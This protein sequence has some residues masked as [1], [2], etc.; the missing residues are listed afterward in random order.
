MCFPTQLGR[1]F[2]H[3]RRPHLE[4]LEDRTLPS[5]LVALTSYGHLLTFDSS[6]PDTILRDVRIDGPDLSLRRALGAIAFKTGATAH[7]ATLYGVSI[8]DFS[9]DHV[10]AIDPVSGSAT[11]LA[12]ESLG[13]F[14]ESGKVGASFDPVSSRLRVV[15]DFDHNVQ[16]GVDSTSAVVVQTDGKTHFATGDV[17]E[18]FGAHINE[19]V[20]TNQVSGATSTTLYA[21]VQTNHPLL[22][23]I[24]GAGGNPAPDNGEVHTIAP[25]A[26]LQAITI[27]GENN[28]A[29]GINDRTV[30][31]IDL[32]SGA[33]EIVGTL[34]A[35]V[36]SRGE[37][38]LS[39]AVQPGSS[40]P[41][42][43]VGDA[44]VT[45]VSGQLVQAEL[46]VTLS[47][48]SSQTVTVHYATID[49]SARA[50]QDYKAA[51]PG[52]M[53]QFTRGEVRKPIVVPIR[54]TA[55]PTAE[56]FFVQLSQPRHADLGRS[57]GV[58]TIRAAGQAQFLA[59]IYRE[60]FSDAPN[61]AT[62]A[63]DGS[64]VFEHCFLDGSGRHCIT[65]PQDTSESG[66]G[67]HLGSDATPGN[68]ALVLAGG[69]DRIT[70]PNLAAGVH[71][72]LAQVTLPTSAPAVVHV[73]GLNGVYEVLQ[74]PSNPLGT[75]AVG[76][77]HVLPSGAELGPI[78]EIDL[79]YAGSTSVFDDV[80]ILVLPDLPPSALDDFVS[81]RTDTSVT[82]PVLANDS[83][84][85]GIPLYVI[86]HTDPAHGSVIFAPVAQTFI[87][88][89]DANYDSNS[90]ADADT[91]TY[92][93][94]DAL[95]QTAVATVHVFVGFLQ[96]I[97]DR[98][99]AL[100]TGVF[101]VADEM[102]SGSTTADPDRRN[103]QYQLV[104]PSV[105]V[106]QPFYGE[107]LGGMQELGAF[108][109]QFSSANGNM[110]S[111]PI[112]QVDG[113][114]G[115][116]A[117]ALDMVTGVVTVQWLDSLA[118]VGTQIDVSYSADR[119]LVVSDPAQG[120]LVL[121]GLDPSLARAVLVQGPQHGVLQFNEDGT[122]T[123]TPTEHPANMAS[124]PSAVFGSDSFTWLA[125]IGYGMESNVATVTIKQQPFVTR[126]H[127]YRISAQHSFSHTSFD[128][129]QDA[130]LS[131]QND[132]VHPSVNYPKTFIGPTGLLTGDLAFGVTGQLP[133]PNNPGQPLAQ[134]I[135]LLSA[136][137]HGSLWSDKGYLGG[138]FGGNYEN[139]VHTIENKSGDL[140]PDG[141]FW[142]VPADGFVGVDQIQYALIVNLPLNDHPFVFVS[143]ATTTFI[144][145]PP[146]DSTNT[147]GIPAATEDGAPNGDGNG[148]GIPD[149]NEDNVASLPS[150]V[151]SRI[152][153]YVTLESPRTTGNP[154]QMMNVQAIDNPH[155]A[156]TPAGASFP[157]G[158][159]NFQVVGLAPGDA[160]TVKIYL[161][162]PL[163]GDPTTWTFWRYGPTP[164]FH[165]DH[166]YQFLYQ[167]PTDADDASTTGAEFL[168]TLDDHNNRVYNRI[169]LHFVD[170]GRG[171]NDLEANGIITDPGGIGIALQPTARL[172]PDPLAAGATMLTV[173]GTPGNDTITLVATDAVGGI[174]V[175]VNGQLLGHFQP[176]G[177]IVVNTQ[178][179]NDIL[180]LKT[181]SGTG[182]SGVR[183]IG[184]PA[185][186]IAGN[187]NDLI[188]A[189]G[190]SAAN[191]L[192]AGTG[193]SKL[194]GGFGRDILIAGQQSTFQPGRG[195][196]LL[197]KGITP[198]NSD[199]NALNALVREWSAP[200]MKD[201]VRIDHLLH[202][203]GANGS[204]VL[205]GAGAVRSA[206]NTLLATP[207]ELAKPVLAGPSGTLPVTAIMPPFSWNP[208]TRA[209]RY[210]IHLDDLA[211]G[212]PVFLVNLDV[213]GTTW[214]PTTPLLQGHS[215]R[216]W[217]QACDSLGNLSL[218]SS[219]LAFH[220][221]PLAKPTLTGPKGPNAGATPT[222]AW[223]AVLG[224]DHYQII[225]E[226]VI[227]SR[228]ALVAT[229]ANVSTTNWAP[230]F[231]L[232]A[233]V[234]YRWRLRAL[235][236]GGSVGEWSE[237]AA[238]SV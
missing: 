49:D 66:L 146:D 132:L 217:V 216:W 1:R 205:P 229:D 84:E 154:T 195:D 8:K 109:G 88:H 40:E 174:D 89:P 206:H 145:V 171:D 178:D 51:A 144:S 2:F 162:S 173:S 57:L 112:T 111:F 220:I 180:R 201:A 181:K 75:V 136:P 7:S 79:V 60:D 13:L 6:A 101:A 107:V 165:H 59:D 159:F 118:P 126:P 94:A 46:W 129:Q 198:F 91:F 158:F 140:N 155:P 93:V 183:R 22:V 77:Q 203:G 157:I 208:V 39:L 5:T 238:F 150:I 219:A 177:H 202:G 166:W 28:L 42:L 147:T 214:T 143:A 32:N 193:T 168:Y 211:R 63:F 103:S 82:I 43:S 26:P 156:D 141:S 33:T 98:S 86:D 31:A 106:G 137:Q 96:Q 27:G 52:A 164:H 50:G 172:D 226:N 36:L 139:T 68:P 81:T 182:R 148:D 10:F 215:Y 142:Y 21:I 235:G 64:G 138:P 161:S 65:N 151:D 16:V 170:G 125:T 29:Y 41:T 153:P 200:G 97:A 62:P 207:L 55:P 149:R 233:G 209:D 189:S 95:G 127:A 67:F 110:V 152:G 53:V 124:L 123:Y 194:I 236:P 56:T 25:I 237:F 23:T 37:T 218:M 184:V 234:K 130:F 212:Q 163:P 100:D 169:I 167:H 15:D 176:T 119:P 14:T 188:D 175:T 70:F 78:Q 80:Q 133:D 76:E 186:V 210:Q 108:D 179:G 19:M 221:A 192:A 223:G 90:A 38:I 47:A 114:F 30:Y 73:V 224:A 128:T 87:Y 44:A 34:P 83:G 9:V 222:F 115:Q 225:L 69:M 228:P 185:I 24:G 232:T 45:V 160:T 196:D 187:G 231:A 35:A 48:P 11:M 54:R 99:I 85:D 92:T 113:N 121:A 74:D 20:Y 72:G 204:V 191:V 12:G 61:S 17:N 213:V 18:R 117:G 131:L 122:F 190:S 120:L 102:D 134:E 197:V 199:L 58:G 230:P 116:M 135:R 104:H 3:R 105:L 4:W 71:V 227:T